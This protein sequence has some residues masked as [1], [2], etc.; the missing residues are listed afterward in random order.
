[1]AGAAVTINV[2][3]LAAIKT[4]GIEVDMATSLLLSV[5]ATISACG[6]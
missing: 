6:A 3:T 5:L 2:M 1:M 4:L